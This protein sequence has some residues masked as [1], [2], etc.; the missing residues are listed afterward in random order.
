MVASPLLGIDL[1]NS[2]SQTLDGH[3]NGEKIESSSPPASNNQDNEVVEKSSEQAND[4]ID[5]DKTECESQSND[6][7]NDSVD[8]I[9]KEHSDRKKRYYKDNIKCEIDEIF[10]EEKY[11]CDPT[12]RNS[13][14]K[15]DGTRIQLQKYEE[16]FEFGLRSSL[17]LGIILYRI[18]SNGLYLLEYNSLQGYMEA[19]WD[20]SKSRYYQLLEAARIYFHL[21]AVMKAEFLPDKVHPLLALKNS[22]PDKKLKVHEA[23]AYYYKAMKRMTNGKKPTASKIREV[24]EEDIEP[25]KE[26]QENKRKEASRKAFKESTCGKYMNKIIGDINSIQNEMEKIYL[27]HGD[28]RHYS[29]MRLSLWD[30]KTQCDTIIREIELSE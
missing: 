5:K 14:R 10:F 6:N 30:I 16:K 29:K 27:E 22:T 8:N 19:R 24:I 7:N 23:V 12:G 21:E 1:C 13:F 20:M 9:L 2:A 28:V 3:T 25:D 11:W 26:T 17:D 4:D 15:T 18:N